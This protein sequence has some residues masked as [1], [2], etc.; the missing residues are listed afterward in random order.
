MQLGAS[1][2]GKA[3]ALA[4]GAAGF[5]VGV[6]GSTL[7]TG[8]GKHDVT[9]GATGVPGSIEETVHSIETA[10]GIA[11]GLRLDLLDRATINAALAEVEDRFGWLDVLVN[12]GVYR[13]PVVMQSIA[14]IEMPAAEDSLLGNF[15][16]QLNLN[17]KAIDL[18]LGRGEGV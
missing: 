2:I 16:N 7:R 15:V 1:G 12:N 10:G 8:Q 14:A 18:M 4:L 17:R 6:T 5:A 13:K 11:L 3:I 9:G